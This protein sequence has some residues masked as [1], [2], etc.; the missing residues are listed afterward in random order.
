MKATSKTNELMFHKENEEVQVAILELNII[1]ANRNYELMT[2]LFKN[3]ALNLIFCTCEN[4]FDV[5]YKKLN[6]FT[7]IW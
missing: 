3:E 2:E 4:S 6:I 5:A 1:K 7:G